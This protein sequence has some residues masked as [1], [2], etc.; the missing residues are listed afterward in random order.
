MQ[1]AKHQL[2][3]DL[4]SLILAMLLLATLSAD[5]HPERLSLRI[6]SLNGVEGNSVEFRTN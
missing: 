3:A 6:V 2:T 4:C 1:N 5:W